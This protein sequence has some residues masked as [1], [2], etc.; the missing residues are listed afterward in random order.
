[1]SLDMFISKDNPVRLT[2]KFVDKI[3][4]SWLEIKIPDA[5]EGRCAF[6]PSVLLK[7]YLY[8]YMNS[9]RSSRKLAKECERN[10]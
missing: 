2:D 4:L 1:M 5:V 3:D 9:L 7:L 8:R 10:I 6:H